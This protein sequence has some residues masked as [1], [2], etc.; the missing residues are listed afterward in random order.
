MSNSLMGNMLTEVVME[1][2]IRDKLKMQMGQ[3]KPQKAKGI[4]I[5]SKERVREDSDLEDDEF[6]DEEA[7]KILSRMKVER[8]DEFNKKN[9]KVEQEKSGF[10]EYREIKE[11]EFLNSV[12]KN[13][14]S[15]VHFYH[16]DFERCK[17]IDK[18]LRQIAYTHTECKFFYLNAEKAPFFIQKLAIRT[19]PTIVCFVDGVAKDRIVGFGELGAKDDFTTLELTRRIVKSGVIKPL[20]KEE[21][22]FNLNLGQRGDSDYSDDD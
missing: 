20:N 21:K 22:G 15:V 9:A 7:E 5:K 2:A 14:F 12:T 11:E 18:H 19:L 1:K 13:K 8:I 4:E 16:N 3:Q 10:G 6:F 17:I